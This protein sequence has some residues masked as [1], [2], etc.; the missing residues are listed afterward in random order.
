MEMIQN[1]RNHPLHVPCHP[2]GYL[3][4]LL[5]ICGRIPLLCSDLENLL[6]PFPLEFSNPQTSNSQIV[7]RCSNHFSKRFFIQKPKDDGCEAQ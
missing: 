6:P 1:H 4:S 7:Q 3:Y 5:S 2:F